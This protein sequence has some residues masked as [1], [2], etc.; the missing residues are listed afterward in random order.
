[1]DCCGKL[2]DII[3]G[4]IEAIRPLLAIAL[5]ALAIY[6]MWFASA[7]FMAYFANI[8]WLPAM[9]TTLGST[10][11]AVV[12]FG[13]A[14]LVDSSTVAAIAQ[15]AASTVGKVVGSVIG[16]VAGG[17][18]TGL[19]GPNAVYW[20][21]GGLA[22][23]LLL[24]SDKKPSSGLGTSALPD[25]SPPA[26]LPSTPDFNREPAYVWSDAPDYQGT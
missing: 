21:L 12:A 11:L 22:L 6:F 9:I 23:Y 10:E 14:L 17:V 25:E 4:I 18:T 7:E 3:S 5:V 19:F 15:K 20:L 1:M 16:A 8:T 24:T 13:A 2:G 26:R